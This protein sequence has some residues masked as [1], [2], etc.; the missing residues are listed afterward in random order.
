MNTLSAPWRQPARAKASV[1]PGE[2][3]LARKKAWQALAVQDDLFDRPPARRFV[4]LDLIEYVSRSKDGGVVV[5]GRRGGREVHINV[6]DS[7]VPE[8]IAKLRKPV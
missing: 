3:L 2:E 1:L 4:N 8:L 7:L 5:A 6:P